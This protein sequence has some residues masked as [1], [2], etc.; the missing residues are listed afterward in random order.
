MT[1]QQRRIL[2]RSIRMVE[3]AAAPANRASAN[4]YKR[5][6]AR[7]GKGGTC[8]IGAAMPSLR[9]GGRGG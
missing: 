7:N 4:P 9:R 6:I 2:A 5:F 3:G 8:S 1:K